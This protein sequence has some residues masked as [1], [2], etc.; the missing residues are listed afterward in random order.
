MS[1]LFFPRTPYEA[2]WR[3]AKYVQ[4]FGG[5]GKYNWAEAV[6]R[7]LVESLDDAAELGKRSI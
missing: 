3:V 5:L 4:D 2:A 1:R 6:G 7:V